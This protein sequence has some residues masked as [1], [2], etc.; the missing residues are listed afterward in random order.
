[1]V[2]GSEWQSGPAFLK[3]PVSEWP[4]RTDIMTGTV[5][6][7]TEELRKQYRHTSFERS[8]S[9][10]DMQTF[11]KPGLS[12]KEPEVQSSHKTFRQ[13]TGTEEH[14]LD[15]I[16]SSTNSWTV[17][18]SKTRMLTRWLELS[19]GKSLTMAYEQGMISRLYLE[20]CLANL[21]NNMVLKL[22][23]HSI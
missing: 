5:E 20:N 18:L 9:R 4:I 16:A 12:L 10:N 23:L 13:S 6:L 17:A 1:M 14:K 7:P 19:R 11:S 21:A 8:S 22:W 2:E 3:K 15:K